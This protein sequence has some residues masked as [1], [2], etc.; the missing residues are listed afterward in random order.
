M[1]NDYQELFK[2]IAKNFLPE[3]VE[4]WHFQNVPLHPRPENGSWDLTK[5]VF[6]L[7]VPSS[8][9]RSLVC[10]VSPD[11]EKALA[12]GFAIRLLERD[13]KK[14]IAMWDKAID[15]EHAITRIIEL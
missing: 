2:R 10:Q 4:L 9:G 14:A 12:E 11:T 1:R 5:T 15:H 13:L 8:V 3:G 7:T 6:G